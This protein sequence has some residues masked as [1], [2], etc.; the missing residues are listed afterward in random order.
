M[1]TSV[2]AIALASLFFVGPFCC[3]KPAQVWS[4]EHIILP[5]HSPGIS[6]E[7]LVDGAPLGQITH[8]GQTYVEAPW[9]KDFELRITCPK[10]HRYLAVCSVD[11]LSIMNG[12][13]ASSGDDGYVIEDGSVTIPGFRLDHDNVAHFQFGDKSASYAK[14]MRKPENIGVIGLKVFADANETVHYWYS[15]VRRFYHEPPYF[16]FAP[17][18]FDDRYAPG[19]LEYGDEGSSDLPPTKL[20]SFVN[21]APSGLI[22]G[23]EGS[24]H[25]PPIQSG[26][27]MKHSIGNLTTGHSESSLPSAWGYCEP[28]TQQS[29]LDHDMGTI[30]GSRTS[31][32]T[33]DVRFNRGAIIASFS[34]EYASHEKLVKA[35]ILPSGNIIA[36]PTPNPFPA[37]GCPPPPGWH[38]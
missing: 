29:N 23:N 25:L 7:V 5:S 11:G 31:F 28:T 24:N 17:Q 16:R 30:F 3:L 15:P 10:Y 14:L 26:S 1:K 6:L 27:F 19:D 2:I 21:P 38:G 4:T 18:I 34:I 13:P 33:R 37:D 12:R 32:K 20:D 22:Y 8:N 9:N 36:S 35:G